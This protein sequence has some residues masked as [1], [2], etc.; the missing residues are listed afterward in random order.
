M[1]KPGV[2]AGIGPTAAKSHP[3]DGPTRR[4]LQRAT[5][6]GHERLEASLRLTAPDLTLDEYARVLGRFLSIYTALEAALEKHAAALGRLGLDWSERRK[7]P[8]LRR[9]LEA[10]G[11][12]RALPRPVL[13]QLPR[14]DSLAR[15]MGCLYVTE[16][17]TLGGS[18][19]GPS[20]RR[21]LGI[22]PE[23]G[24][25]FIDSYGS[26]VRSQWQRYC[27]ALERCATDLPERNE[28]IAAG[29]A[30]FELFCVSVA[31]NDER[32]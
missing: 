3:T 12:G 18:V 29:I 4:A 26:A 31:D 14:L 28:A 15:A 25:A 1:A 20:V 19:I 21:A 22:G 16:G 27:A 7:V 17:A 10:L 9:D 23:N 30:T 32:E 24:G 6:S 2:A 11:Y 8:L 5:R 13:H